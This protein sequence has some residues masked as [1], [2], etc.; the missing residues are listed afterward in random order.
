MKLK[1]FSKYKVVEE[2]TVVYD[3][4]GTGAYKRD[5]SVT[6]PKGSIVYGDKIQM[7]GSQVLSINAKEFGYDGLI[8]VP[9]KKVKYMFPW[10]TVIAVVVTVGVIIFFSTRDN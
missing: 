6:I 7:G 10:V 9:I 8:Q 2:T 4:Y 5:E 1:M 3:S